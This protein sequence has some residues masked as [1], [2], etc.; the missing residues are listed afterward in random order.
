MEV[1]LSFLINIIDKYYHQKIIF[2]K[3]KKLKLKVVLDVGAHKGEFAKP[4]S[5][6][7]M[8]KKIYAFEPQK[9]IF[10]ECNK[11]L[12]SIKKIKY[13]N[14]ALSDRHGLKKIKINKKTSTSTFSLINNNSKWFRFKNLL[15]GQV[16]NSS[17]LRTEYANVTTGDAF[18]SYNSLKNI[19]LLKI[20]TEGHEK[21]VL[22]GFQK[23]LKNNS[24][25]YILL[26]MHLGCM[27]KNY[28]INSIDKYLKKNNFLLK[29][30]YKFPFLPFEDRL[31]F[32]KKILDNN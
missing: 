32:N 25:K 16:N 11:N 5:R 19:D 27:Y 1:I 14:I 13:I 2:K 4:L 17:F 24:I 28:N 12:N 3:L 18:I 22:N 9:I 29:K 6:I 15:L 31:Y 30:K 26:E 20:D 21:S 10:N 8:I 7:L 23:N